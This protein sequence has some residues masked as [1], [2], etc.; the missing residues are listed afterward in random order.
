M[1][2]VVEGPDAS[3]KSTLAKHIVQQ[4]FWGY[5]PGEGPPKYSGEIVE[6]IRRYKS[7]SECVFD[8]HPC[9]SE[10]IYAGFRDKP[11]C[12]TPIMAPLIDEFYESSPLLIYCKG[13]I[14]DHEIKDYDTK[15]HLSMIRRHDA[16]IRAAYDKWAEF[17]EPLVYQAGEDIGPII[18]ACKEYVNGQSTL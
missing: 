18:D 1:I 11:E 12:V 5:V 4:T 8:R 16:G 2:I 6:R 15:E 13:I 9:I 14:G 3:G 10:P 17:R 7:Y